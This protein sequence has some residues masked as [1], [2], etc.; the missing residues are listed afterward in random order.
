[1]DR[2]SEI[3]GEQVQFRYTCLDR[4]VLHGYLTGLQRPGQLVSFFHD[5]VGVAC[6]EPTVLAGRTTAYRR[7]LEQYTQGQGI[8]VVA[9]P[10]G[11]RK[12]ELVQPYYAALGPREGVACVLTSLETTRTFSSYTP[13]RPPLSGD[14]D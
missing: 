1:V 11:V 7:W 6:I 8:A 12:E 3:F 14:P 10:P 2:L 4:I 5:V 9:A 13:Q